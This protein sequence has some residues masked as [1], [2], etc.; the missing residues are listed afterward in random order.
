MTE[1]SRSDG[2]V[3]ERFTDRL[4]EVSKRL[5]CHR[6]QFAGREQ[7]RPKWVPLFRYLYR[8]PGATVSELA[9]GVNAAKSNVSVALERM[10]EQGWVVKT[11]DPDDQRLIRVELTDGFKSRAQELRRAYRRSLAELFHSLSPERLRVADDLLLELNRVLSASLD[12]DRNDE[13]S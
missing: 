9:R 3:I 12:A 6:R 11:P 8:H 7:I 1:K 5:A 4:V 13:P 10:A 2:E